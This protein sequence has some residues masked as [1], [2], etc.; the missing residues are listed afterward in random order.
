M[1]DTQTHPFVQ[2]FI[3]IVR[4]G[5]T[6]LATGAIQSAFSDGGGNSSRASISEEQPEHRETGSEHHASRGPASAS[7]T[8]E[9]PLA[10]GHV[11]PDDVATHGRDPSAETMRHIAAHDI[12]RSVNS[13]VIRLIR[14]EVGAHTTQLGE[15]RVLESLGQGSSLATAAQHGAEAIQAQ[16]AFIR[17]AGQVVGAAAT[18]GTFAARVMEIGWQGATAETVRS[19]AAGFISNHSARIVTTLVGCTNPIWCAGIVSTVISDVFTPTETA[20]PERDERPPLAHQP[21]SRPQLPDLDPAVPSFRSP[22]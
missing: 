5:L 3:Q 16:T 6:Q 8:V 2:F 1:G 11:S 22:R 15:G 9:N 12:T 20:P 14:D 21:L 17:H 13:S 18:T 19:V 4:S 7:S 10:A